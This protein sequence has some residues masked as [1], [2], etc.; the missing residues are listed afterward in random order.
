MNNSKQSKN[1][2]FLVGMM[3]T[4][5]STVGRILANKLGIGFIDSDE[6]IESESSLSIPEIFHTKGESHFRILENEFITVGLPK[7]KHVISCGGGLCIQ[8][9]MMEILKSRGKVLCLWAS[10]EE[11]VKR[12]NS[13]N[14]R[15]LLE[16][17]NPHQKIKEI[18]KERKAI[19]QSSDYLIE[20]DELSPS[21][22][23]NEIESLL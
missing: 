12:T 23:V 18:L 7:E 3:G 8:K 19:Y 9:G 6:W 16:T 14:N 17:K 10:P 1:K 21:E 2:I 20:T 15:P 5:K 22:I 4:G 13:V 11:I